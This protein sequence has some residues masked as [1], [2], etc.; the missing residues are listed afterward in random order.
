MKK[1]WLNILICIGIPLILITALFTISNRAKNNYNY[2]EIIGY[3]KDKQV[4]EYSMN[5]GSG[6]TNIK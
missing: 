4:V 3:F 2:S 6:E 1:T 5:L